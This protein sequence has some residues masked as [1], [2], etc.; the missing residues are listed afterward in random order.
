MVFHYIFSFVAKETHWQFKY[1]LV[2]ISMAINNLGGN[3]EK[4]TDILA[5]YNRNLIP[6][7]ERHMGTEASRWPQ[8]AV[9]SPVQMAAYL[10]NEITR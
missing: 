9:L 10:V 5:S 6:E 8:S 4:N 2:L 1:S 7:K 3:R